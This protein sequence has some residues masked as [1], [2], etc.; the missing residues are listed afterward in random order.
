MLYF[1]RTNV[2]EGNDVNKTNESKE[3]NIFQ[4]WFFLN[5]GFKFQPNVCNRCCDLLMMSMNLSDIVILNFKGSDY[6]YIIS[7]I[8]KNEAINT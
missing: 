4:Y 5:K 1:D 6:R 8:S 7:G 2:S 3:C